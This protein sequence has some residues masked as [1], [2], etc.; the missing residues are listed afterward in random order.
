[1]FP[2]LDQSSDDPL[3][4]TVSP[5]TQA[6]FSLWI[7][8]FWLTYKCD[9]TVVITQELPEGWTVTQKEAAVPHL[10]HFHD[11][12]HTAGQ[13]CSLYT[14]KIKVLTPEHPTLATLLVINSR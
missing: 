6:E 10:R 5:E 11:P 12:Q 2:I 7:K 4:Q 8:D 14:V 13:L 3:G 1:M 9:I